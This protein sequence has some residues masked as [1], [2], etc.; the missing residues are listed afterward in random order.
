MQVLQS[1]RANIVCKS[2]I[3]S[4]LSPRQRRLL[5]K[6]II[7][8]KN[9]GIVNDNN[10]QTFSY[11]GR[12]WKCSYEVHVK[13][14]PFSTFHSPA[15]VPDGRGIILRKLSLYRT[16]LKRHMHPCEFSLFFGSSI[17]PQ[18]RRRDKWSSDINCNIF[19]CFCIHSFASSQQ[20]CLFYSEK[21]K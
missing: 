2:A 9:G 15:S 4:P 3:L 17:F 1:T 14:V 19:L 11:P 10:E 12:G 8:K 7:S 20:P 6:A 21:K 16:I 13:A 5:T 18:K